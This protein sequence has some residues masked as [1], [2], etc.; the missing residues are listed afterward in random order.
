MKYFYEEKRDDRK[1]SGIIYIHRAGSF[2]FSDGTL[3]LK[4]GKGLIVVRKYF[5]KV[6]K[7]CYYGPISRGLA[8]DIFTHERFCEVFADYAHKRGKDGYPFIDVRKFMWALRMKPLKKD[9]FEFFF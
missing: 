7:I 9:I 6:R 3:F 2:L 1:L 5:D 4:D 8:N